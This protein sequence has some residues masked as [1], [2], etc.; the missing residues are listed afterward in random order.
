[1]G[2][3]ARAP[4]P[5]GPPRAP[6]PGQRGPGR[7]LLALLLVSPDCPKG[8]PHCERCIRIRIGALDGKGGLDDLGVR[9]SLDLGNLLLLLADAAGRILQQTGQADQRVVRGLDCCLSALGQLPSQ[10]DVH[11]P[12]A[13]Q[14][15]RS[16]ILRAAPGEDLLYQRI[17]SAAD[18]GQQCQRVR[19][20]HLFQ[21]GVD[22]RGGQ[23][24]QQQ[25]LAVRITVLAQPLRAGLLI[26]GRQKDQ[27][28]GDAV[29][30]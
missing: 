12:C 19:Q 9:L 15:L 21:S 23:Q 7:Y 1:M 2:A 16:S 28:V 6:G 30:R 26:L 14:Q 18:L 3:V 29:E 24:L 11:Q 20:L 13:G 17:V 10:R 22:R 25:R 5:R 4:G 8:K 27:G